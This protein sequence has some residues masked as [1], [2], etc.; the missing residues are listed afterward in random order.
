MQPLRSARMTSWHWGHT[1]ISPTPCLTTR[2]VDGVLYRQPHPLRRALPVGV[3]YELGCEEV[4]KEV[5]IDIT[6]DDETPHRVSRL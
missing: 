6:T 4:D 1:L 3:V 2:R 5:C